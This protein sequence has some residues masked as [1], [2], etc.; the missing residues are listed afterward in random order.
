MIK[1]MIFLIFIAVLI[2]MMGCAST[3]LFHREGRGFHISKIVLSSSIPYK[4][5]DY[6]ENYTFVPFEQFYLLTLFENMK[7]VKRSDGLCFSLLEEV[8]IYG[9]DNEIIF[10]GIRYDYE[11]C[12]RDD[13][14]PEVH[15][16]MVN[17][18][19]ILPDWKPGKYTIEVTLTDRFSDTSDT[20][21]I[22]F[23]VKI[24]SEKK[25]AI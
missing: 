11:G 24:P 6:V 17:P 22:S 10:S 21:R 3:N 8:T 5:M 18:C 19:M 25:A 15:N 12:I 14:N 20:A 4:N 16:Y 9:P 13:Y 1:R 2:L 23:K 7:L